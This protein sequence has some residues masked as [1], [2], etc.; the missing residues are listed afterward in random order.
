M[1]TSEEQELLNE[2]PEAL[3]TE[4]SS[5]VGLTTTCEPAAIRAKAEYRQNPLRP[6]AK[7]GRNKTCHTETAASRSL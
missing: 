5:D 2:L 1:L 6:E 7:E 3:W 4:G